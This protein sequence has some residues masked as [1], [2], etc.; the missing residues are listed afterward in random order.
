[1][2]PRPFAA[3]EWMIAWRYLR[4]RRREGGVSVMS[5][6]SLVGVSLAVFA[7]I[8]TLAVRSGFRTEFVGTIIGANAHVTLYDIPRSDAYGPLPRGIEDYETLTEQV[9]AVPGVTRAAPIIQG[10]VMVTGPGGSSAVLGRQPREFREGRRHRLGRGA[11]PGPG[12][13][14]LHQADLARGRPGPLRDHAADLGLPGNL[15]LPGGP[16]GYR[17][18]QALQALRRGATPR[19]RPTRSKSW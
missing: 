14:R 10:Q 3:H 17:P 9:A 18:H 11:Q 2:T 15:H 8:A 16:L 1:M 4:A 12:R 7:L 19:A 6:I 13:R 5:I